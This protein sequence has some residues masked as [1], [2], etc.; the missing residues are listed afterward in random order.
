M[1]N[2]EF[3]KYIFDSKINSSGL[4]NNEVLVFHRRLSKLLKKSLHLGFHSN[5]QGKYSLWRLI[6]NS[7]LKF[8]GK[9]EVDPLNFAQH[10][11]S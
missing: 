3:Q 1:I 11:Q 10:C 4:Q 2:I 8:K 9:F 5:V 7:A 6:R